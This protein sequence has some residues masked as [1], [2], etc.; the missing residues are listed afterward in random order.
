MK[1]TS[2]EDLC[3]VPLSRSILQQMIFVGMSVLRD[4]AHVILA[5]GIKMDFWDDRKQT[6]INCIFVVLPCL[7]KKIILVFILDELMCLMHVDVL[8]RRM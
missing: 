8:K 1:S 2:I 7:H 5:M 6:I 3:D 4:I